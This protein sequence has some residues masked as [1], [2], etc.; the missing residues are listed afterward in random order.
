MGGGGITI[1]EVQSLAFLPWKICLV[2]SPESHSISLLF[3]RYIFPHV[4]AVPRA[5]KG[6]YP[7]MADAKGKSAHP[8]LTRGFSWKV[9]NVLMD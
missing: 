2:R 3:A 6:Q 1:V 9:N 5:W 4:L 8:R 7:K